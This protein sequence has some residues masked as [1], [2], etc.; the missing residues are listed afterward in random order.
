MERNQLPARRG[1]ITW[2]AKVGGRTVYLSV[3]SGT[4]PRELFIRVKGPGCTAEVVGM[5]DVVARLVS[6]ALQ[7]GAPLEK[8]GDLLLNT[9][10]E[11]AGIVQQHT[12]IKFCS[13]LIDFVG[14][15]LLI[16]YG[17]RGDLAVSTVQREVKD[18]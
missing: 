8:V 5:Y 7:Y 2:K 18:E 6:L 14:K 13:S 16:E 9:K 17:G 1:C 12:A 10:F 15:H 4:P 3:D 11:P